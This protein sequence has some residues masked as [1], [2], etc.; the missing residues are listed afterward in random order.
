[1]IKINNKSHCTGC[2]ACATICP[3]SCIVLEADNEGFMYPRVMQD[4]CIDCGLCEKVC[5]VE[6]KKVELEKASPCLYA[7]YHN[8]EKIRYDSSSGGIFS[9]VAEKVLEEGGTIC[10]KN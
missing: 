2:T 8:N 7:A 9:A 5:P 1:M 10:Y 4:M 6:K 3:K